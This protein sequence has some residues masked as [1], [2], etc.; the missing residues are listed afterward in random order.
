MLLSTLKLDTR[1][2]SSWVFF[3]PPNYNK[4]S[5]WFR[6]LGKICSSNWIISPRIGMK[7]PKHI[8]NH[9][10]DKLYEVR[11]P[12]WGIS[13]QQYYFEGNI[14]SLPPSAK[15]QRSKDP[16]CKK[17]A[18]RWWSDFSTKKRCKRKTNSFFRSLNSCKKCTFPSAGFCM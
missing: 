5:W 11:R 15:I 12:R 16:R 8:W 2:K 13:N 1:G 3:A 4:T 7:I 17:F 6:P 14:Q 10:L 9:Q 18:R